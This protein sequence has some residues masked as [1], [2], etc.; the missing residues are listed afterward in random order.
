MKRRRLLKRSPLQLHLATR[1]RV[2]AELRRVE[3]SPYIAFLLDADGVPLGMNRMARALLGPA[4][5]YAPGA[6]LLL[7]EEGLPQARAHAYWRGELALLGADGGELAVSQMIEFHAATEDEAGF[8]SCRAYE[9][10]DYEAYESRLRFKRLFEEHPHPMWVYDLHSLRFLVVNAAAVSHY[11]YSESEF[12]DMTIMDIR[13][14][15]ERARLLDNLARTLPKG[16]SRSGLWIHRKKDGSLIDVDM[17]SHSVTISGQPARFVFAHDVSEQIRTETALH[18]AQETQR[19]VIDHI[20]H[21][22]FWKDLDGR[23]RGCNDV[24]ARAAGLDSS[25]AVLGKDD[26]AFPWAA[27]A[28]RIRADDQ[29]IVTSGR[30]QLDRQD[31]L[32]FADGSVHWFLIN[33]LPLHDQRGNIIGVLGTIEDVSLRRQAELTLQ[34]QGRAIEAS[35]NAIVITAHRDGADA[36]EYA[37]PAFTQLSGYQGAEIIGRNLD[38][39]LGEPVDAD[40]CVALHGAL[41]ACGEVTILLRNYHKDGSLFW[42]QLHV[43]PVRDAQGALSHHVCVLNDMT[44]VMRYQ[45]QLEHQANHDALTALPNRNLF[46][47]RLAQAIA[48]AQRYGKAVWVVCID[49]DNFKLVNDSLGHQMG[50]QLLRTIGGRLRNCIRDS[51]TVARLGGDE[52]M[53]IL[54]DAQ[55]VGAS[56]L[57][58][59]LDAVSAPVLLGEQEVIVTCSVGVSLYPDDG[60]DAPTLLKHADIAMY[61]AKEG[62]RNKVQFYEAAM[63]ARIAERALIEAQLR[64]ALARDELSLHYQPRVDLRSGQVAGMEAL[65]RWHHPQLGMVAPS[66]FIGVAEETGLIVPIGLWVLHSACAQNKA[67]QEAGL[68]RLRVAVN[69]SARQFRDPALADEIVRVLATTGLEAQ[70]L[71]LELTESVMMHNVDEAVA[72]LV[73]LKALGVALS[74]D[75]FG[76][77][78]SS[79]AYLK[80]FPLDYLKIDQS[81]IH[82]MLDDPSGAAIVRSVI[83]LGHSLNFKVIAEGVETEAQLAYLRRYHCDEMQ[84][85][86]FSRPLPVEQFGRL[87]A[88]EASLP[89][90][91]TAPAGQR[92]LLLLDDEVNVLASL[93][94]L[95]RR[96]AYTILRADTPQQA[97]DLLALHEVQVIVSDQRMPAMTGTEFF[98]RVKKMYPGTI[99]IILSGYT[100]LDS[101]LSAING[102]EIYRFFTKPWDDQNLR[103]N[104]REAF[105]YH[106]LIHGGVHER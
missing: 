15:D 46:G 99:R 39:L 25:A 95:F 32:L 83:A 43:A 14:V 75:D 61:R 34:L 90:A 10:K 19:L 31:H 64:H 54:P 93:A 69:L 48:Y 102:G 17:S 78:Y 51:D 11:G 45:A 22:I 35:V 41:Q 55:R 53:L 72:A 74:I 59:V 52:F 80:R 77:G 13:P 49:L 9:L 91:R 57:R 28:A 100:D 58:A 8:F 92:T 96:D 82:D 103:E 94:R 106:Q 18:E 87:L 66:R 88:E 29:A 37:N 79:L 6:A 63:H 5:S 4:P 73:H 97:F 38:F 76:T 86:Y 71:E 33:K 47:D 23:Y 81:F 20:P 3:F 12:L 24:F 67:W 27:N 50:D 101:V 60:D 2:Q 70:Y 36:I 89:G 44:A 7:R 104:I 56:P 98:S 30:A 40:D 68:A 21:Q 84:G 62:G 42:N 1:S 65:L 26:D 16:A 105:A 85:Y